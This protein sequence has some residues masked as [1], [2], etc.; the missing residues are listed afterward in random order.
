MPVQLLPASA[1]AFAP[2]SPPEIVL[3]SKAELWL[4]QTL[5]RINRVKRPLNNVQQHVRCLTETLG[6][7]AAIWSLASLMLPKEPDSKLRRVQRRLKL[8]HYWRLA[9]QRWRQMR[10][11]HWRMRPLLLPKK[12]PLQLSDTMPELQILR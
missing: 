4:T 1:Q 8:R 5:K 7:E 9:R 3:N 11:K 10:R 12:R 2:R 6:G